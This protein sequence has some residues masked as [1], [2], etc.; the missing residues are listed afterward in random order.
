MNR[1]M[2]DDCTTPGLWQVQN[3]LSLFPFFMSSDGAERDCDRKECEQERDIKRKKK[4][5]RENERR[6]I[7]NDMRDRKRERI[8]SFSFSHFLCHFLL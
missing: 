2:A 7:E 3:E 6:C 5:E 4:G 8:V 1:I